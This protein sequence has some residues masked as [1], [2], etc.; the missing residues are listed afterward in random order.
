M[1]LNRGVAAPDKPAI[2]DSVIRCKQDAH[3]RLVCMQLSKRTRGHLAHMQD[4]G[5]LCQRGYVHSTI[6]A[7]PGQQL[8]AVAAKAQDHRPGHALVKDVLHA[9]KHHV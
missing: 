4:S 3:D 7:S 8:G 1:M 2:F 9:C 6:D 5:R